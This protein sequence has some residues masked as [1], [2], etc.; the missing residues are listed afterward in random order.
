MTGLDWGALWFWTWASNIIHVS[1]ILTS[2]PVSCCLFTW[3]SVSFQSC[4]IH[5]APVPDL[6][7]CWT[8]KLK[9]VRHRTVAELASGTYVPWEGPKSFIKYPSFCRDAKGHGLPNNHMQKNGLKGPAKAC[10]WSPSMGNNEPS[11]PGGTS[12]GAVREQGLTC[13]ARWLQ[14]TQASRT[15]NVKAGRLICRGQHT[16]FFWC[17]ALVMDES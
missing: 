17:E 2:L 16:F 6:I 14:S 15:V 1:L 7:F 12:T 11:P 5:V 8:V 10:Q 9:D 3:I 13:T 4:P